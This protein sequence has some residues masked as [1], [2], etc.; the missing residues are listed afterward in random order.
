MSFKGIFFPHDH[1]KD[2][3]KALDGL[4]GW[5]VL[6]VLFGHAANQGLTP[7]IAGGFLTRGKL[8]VYLFFLISAYL[9]TRQAN[10]IRLDAG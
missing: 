8:G 2:H 6:L 9:P 5:A 10:N 1:R 7:W 4:R 3:H